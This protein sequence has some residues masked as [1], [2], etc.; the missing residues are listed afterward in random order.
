MIID[1]ELKWPCVL[2]LTQTH[3]HSESPCKRQINMGVAI[4]AFGKAERGWKSRTSVAWMTSGYN[5]VDYQKMNHQKAG[6]I[7]KVRFHITF[8]WC[9]S[10]TFSS[11]IGKNSI[12]TWLKWKQAPLPVDPV[13]AERLPPP[14]YNTTLFLC[15]CAGSADVS[16]YKP[17]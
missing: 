1:Q 13:S 4:L 14:H 15:H 16:C 6:V 12:P 17:V 5:W 3:K 7:C 8:F 11:T 9:I 2:S 10:E